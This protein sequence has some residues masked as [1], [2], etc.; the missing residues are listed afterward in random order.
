MEGY[1]SR[2]NQHV[3]IDY[4]NPYSNELLS[5]RTPRVFADRI[6]ESLKGQGCKVVVFSTGHRPV[7]PD[8]IREYLESK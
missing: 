2:D 3:I 8:K 7:W 6:I 1:C 4:I 5:I